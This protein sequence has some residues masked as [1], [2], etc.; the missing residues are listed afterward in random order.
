VSP[1][2][3]GGSGLDRTF[4]LADPG[5]PTVV[6]KVIAIDGRGGPLDDA[7]VLGELELVTPVGQGDEITLPGGMRAVVTQI[8]DRID[9][10]SWT[11]YVSVVDD[12][13]DPA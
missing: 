10:A 9:G 5:N 7:P 4:E 6:V 11:Q 3:V 8:V 13:I 1:R 2:R 12:W